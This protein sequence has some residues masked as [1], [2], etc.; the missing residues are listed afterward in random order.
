MGRFDTLNEIEKDER[1][2]KRLSVASKQRDFAFSKRTGLLSFG[3]DLFNFGYDYD[4][5][6]NFLT[7]DQV[8]SLATNNNYLENILFGYNKAKR[9]SII[10]NSVKMHR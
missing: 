8:I 3:N 7:Y 6:N 9:S 2:E 4:K 10:A 1:L 5:F